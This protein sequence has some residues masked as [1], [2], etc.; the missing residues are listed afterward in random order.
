ME[1]SDMSME[2]GLHSETQ[3]RI[4][5]AAGEIFS[6]SGYG[7]TT[8]RAISERAGVNVAAVNYHFG[9]KKNLY[10]AVLNYWRAKAF[11]KY[12]FDASDLSAPPEERLTA[13]IRVLLFRVLDEGE[14]SR[15]ARLMAQEFIRPTDGLGLVVEEVI[16]PL[17]KFHL[18]TV[19]QLLGEE[20][21]EQTVMLCCASVVGQVF[22]FYVGRH[23][24]R[25][26]L[27][28]ESLS[29]QEIEAI[30]Q[31]IARFSLYGIKAIAKELGGKSR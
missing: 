22:Q 30:A 31:H 11:E 26:L 7:H 4:I 10:M 29:T 16:R 14:G 23:V 25:E 24:M 20:A 2:E 28:R 15:F 13:F 3:A 17:F 18:A 27:N 19:R 1:R 5:E 8:I 9:G 21:D 6:E 12:P